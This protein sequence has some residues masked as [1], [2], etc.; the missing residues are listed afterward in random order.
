MPPLEMASRVGSLEGAPDPFDYYDQLGRRARDDLVSIL[1]D[2]WSFEGKRM[3]DFGCG[4]GRTLRH[5]A[6]EAGQGEF[7]GCDI[8][9]GSVEWMAANLTPPFHVFQNDE[10]PPL[11]QPDGFFDLIWCVSV[12]THLTDTWSAWMLELRR[13]LA[14]DGLLIVT[15][16]GEGMS[17]MIVGQPWDEERVGMQVLRL[18]QSW[19]LGGPMVLHSPWWIKEHW[20]RPFD[21]LEIRPDGFAVDPPIGQGSV[22]LRNNGKPITQEE[23]ERVDPGDP[24]ELRA[25]QHNLATMADEV[26]SLRRTSDWLEAQLAERDRAHEQ[27]E[28]AHADVVGSTSWRVTKPLRDAK[29]RVD[30]RRGRDA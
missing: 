22:L 8:H 14:P 17:E 12:F 3:L 25:L 4:A 6:P 5:F 11:D 10:A 1:P 9:A 15:F 20:G 27:H 13:V 29:R 2:D 24:R 28:Q 18:G 26:T 21:V 23:L 19:D 7:W 30:E 16:M